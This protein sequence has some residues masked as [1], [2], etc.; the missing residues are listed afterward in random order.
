METYERLREYVKKTGVK[1]YILAEKCGYTP[2]EFSLFI[3]GKKKIN[4]DDIVIFCN[5]LNITPNDLLGFD[6]SA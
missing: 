4:E 5:L 1:H 2:R 3:N 6:E